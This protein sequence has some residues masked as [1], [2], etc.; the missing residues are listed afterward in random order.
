MKGG[1]EQR[2]T[3]RLTMVTYNLNKGSRESRFP[4]NVVDGQT[5]IRTDGTTFAFME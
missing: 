3:Q 5:D 2:A 1:K 4:L